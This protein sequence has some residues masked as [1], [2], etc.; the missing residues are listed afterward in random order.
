M[1]VLGRSWCFIGKHSW[2]LTTPAK[3]ADSIS[4]TLSL[5]SQHAERE[6][7]HCGKVQYLDRQCLD[8]NPP[9]YVSQWVDKE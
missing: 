3:Y 1:L 9:E 4:Y 8:L 6:C 2:V 7:K 5:P